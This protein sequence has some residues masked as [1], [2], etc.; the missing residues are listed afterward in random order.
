V[1]TIISSNAGL[2]SLTLPVSLGEPPFLQQNLMSLA[3]CFLV[4]VVS[5]VST[6]IIGSPWLDFQ[7]EKL[8]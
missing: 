3:R 4:V 6:S 7:L 5:F 2:I 1:I 8:L